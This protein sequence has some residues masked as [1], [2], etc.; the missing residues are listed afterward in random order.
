ML[1]F[2]N[3]DAGTK[4]V[5]GL[6][7]DSAMKMVREQAQHADN[8]NNRTIVMRSDMIASATVFSA[9]HHYD[10]AI[11]LMESVQ[12]EFDDDEPEYQVARWHI[13]TLMVLRELLYPEGEAD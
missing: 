5:I 9:R 3:P 7:Y 1:E 6:N 11:D 13:E 4:D 8:P 10:L 12:R 2:P